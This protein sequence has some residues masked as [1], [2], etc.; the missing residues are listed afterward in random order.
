MAYVCAMQIFLIG[1]AAQWPGWNAQPAQWIQSPE[2][3]PAGSVLIDMLFDGS[4]LRMAQLEAHSGPVWVNDVSGAACS[5]GFVRFNGWRG[6]AE[7]PRVEAAAGE[8]MRADAE[9]VAQLSGKELDW[10]PDTPG[11]VSPRVVAMIINEAF[12]TLSEG[13]S[14]KEEINTAMKLGT[15]Y[16]H[17]PFEWAALIGVKNVAS[18]LLALAQANPRYA[19]CP[20]LLTEAGIA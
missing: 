2:E 4:A 9:A 16:P 1:D 10:L 12:H 15:A 5:K 7:K 18:L 14:T 19:P 11:F 13:V 8:A 20:L 6:F 3:A 17:G